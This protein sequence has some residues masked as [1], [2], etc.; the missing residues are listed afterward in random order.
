MQFWNDLRSAARMLRHEPGFAA[1]AICTVALGVGANTAIFSIVDG[2]LLRPLPYGD[3]ARLVTLREVIPAIAQTYP[4]LPV[5]ARHFTEWRQRAS[6]F[7]HIS[8][9]NS[10]SAAMTGAGEPEQLD[11][12]RVSADLFE[13][14]G[15]QPAMGRAFAP[16]EDRAGHERVAILSD[17]LWRRRFHANRAI[18][19]KTIQLDS[20]SYTVVG[21]LPAWFRFPDARILEMGQISSVK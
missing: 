15:V 9:V 2:V 13:T 3:P 8:A 12:A 21:I 6:S 16:G 5:S 4:T 10:G 14:L 1:V 11:T 19:G 17:T 20:Q 18:L 7:E